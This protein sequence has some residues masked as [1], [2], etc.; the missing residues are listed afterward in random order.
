ML[1]LK[2]LVK[3]NPRIKTAWRRG[4]ITGS[5][6]RLSLRGDFRPMMEKEPSQSTILYKHPF[7]P[8]YLL[9]QLLQTPVQR[10]L[11]NSS[12][13]AIVRPLE[14]ALKI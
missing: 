4:R 3:A 1:F 6:S 12:S 9:I 7:L 8:K 11:L 2:C 5:Q 14:Y 10:K 13:F